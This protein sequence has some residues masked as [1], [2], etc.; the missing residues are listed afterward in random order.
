MIR[1]PPRSTLFPYTTLFRS[2]EELGLSE[3]L[4][5]R[6]ERL[7]E[8]VRHVEREPARE[9]QA[10]YN[11]VNLQ[12]CCGKDVARLVV[13]VLGREDTH[14][15]DGVAMYVGIGVARL[16]NAAVGAVG[17]V[18]AGT[19]R[20]VQGVHDG[21]VLRTCGVCP[22][23]LRVAPRKVF[24]NGYPLINVECTVIVYGM[25]LVEGADE[26]TVVAIVCIAQ[27]VLG[28]LRTRVEHH[29]VALVCRRA[30]DFVYPVG[31][32]GADVWVLRYVPALRQVEPCGAI[33]TLGGFYLLLC[34][35]RV[36][37]V[38]SLTNTED[39][40]VAKAYGTFLGLLRG[41][42]HTAACSRG[43]S[44]D[45][46]RCGILEYHDALDVVE[47]WNRRAGH[48]INHPKYIVAV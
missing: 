14:R 1:R 17:I 33:R 41:Y 6:V 23:R 25:A 34:G 24:G 10:R 42:E 43:S 44:V 16:C 36:R 29:V 40:V 8:V 5:D 35:E 15:V 28:R 47:R 30:E 2:V 31:S 12:R 32:V 19:R 38:G 39:A 3:L 45:G 4:A 9:L 22:A 37:Q 27:S 18:Y 7:I 13:D 11:I 46:S 21:T 26:H 20:H 48:T